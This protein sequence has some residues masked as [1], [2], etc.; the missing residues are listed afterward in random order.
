[1]ALSTLVTLHTR[2][3]QHMSFSTHCTLHTRHSTHT[4]LSTQ[5]IL[6]T[7]HSTHTS[8]S[9]YDTL[10]TRHSP[11]TAHPTHEIIFHDNAF[12]IITCNPLPM[13]SSRTTLFTGHAHYF[14]VRE[15]IRS[16]RYYSLSLSRCFVL[17]YKASII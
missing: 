6:H 15:E 16:N 4:L 11:H 1:M 9:T 10:H 13:S 7:R 12:R 17:I 8:L 5:G 3:F 14:L 2:N